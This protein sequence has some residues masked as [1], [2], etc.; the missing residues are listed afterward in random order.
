MFCYGNNTCVLRSLIFSESEAPPTK[1]VKTSS[2]VVEQAGQSDRLLIDQV[3]DVDS[4]FD[5]VSGK[6]SSKIKLIV[7]ESLK[8]MRQF[9]YN[10]GYIIIMI[11]I[12]WIGPKVCPVL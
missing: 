9:H 8:R 10:Y 7:L 6:P 12:L 4:I 3:T 11:I 5:E 1:K 2:V